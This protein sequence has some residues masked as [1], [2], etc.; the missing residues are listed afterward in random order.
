[1][2]LVPQISEN[3]NSSTSKGGAH[4]V[5]V[6]VNRFLDLACFKSLDTKDWIE[7][8]IRNETILSPDSLAHRCHTR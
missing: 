1:M 7:L 6:V 8:F 4:E 5:I 2:I 3:A